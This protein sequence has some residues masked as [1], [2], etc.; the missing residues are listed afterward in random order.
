MDQAAQLKGA[1]D[2]RY[3]IER[4][5]GAGGMATVYL[6]RDVRHNRNVALKVLNPELGAVLGVERFLAEISVTANLQHPNLLPLFD[7]GDAGGLLFYVMPFVEGE[8][9][10]ARLEREKQLPVDEA[11][12]IAVAV[13]SAL[14]YAH[15][16]GVIHRDLKPEN[17][18]LQAGQPVIA[19]FGIALAV[20]K[21]GGNRITQT[22]LSLGTPQYMSPEQATGDRVIDGRSDIYSLAAV[23]YELLTGDPPYM[24]STSQAIIARVLTE[25]PRGVRATRASVP[26]HV[27]ATIARALEK[28]PADRFATAREFAEALQGRGTVATAAQ[29]AQAAVEAPP[30]AVAPP[31]R[32][33]ARVVASRWMVAA[34]VVAGAGAGAAAWSVTHRDEPAVVRFP[35]TLTSPER[36]AAGSFGN[37]IALSPD[38][39]LIAYA[40]IRPG[41]A[42]QIFIRPLADLDA[43]PP[44]GTENGEQ[45]FFSPN[46]QWIGFFTG[47]H[48]MKVSVAGGVATPIADVS[49]VCYGASWGPNHQIVISVSGRLEVV[50]DGGGTPRVLSRLNAT[51]SETQQRWPYVLADG[52]TVLYTSWKGTVLVGASIAVARLDRDSTQS[53]T[54]LDLRGSY[55]LGIVEGQLVY[56]SASAMSGQLMAVP[57]DVRGLRVTGTP[58]PVLDSVLMVA[59]GVAKAAVSRSGSLIHLSGS[60][61]QQLILVDPR[62]VTQSLSP[63]P[64]IFTFPRFSPDGNRI[65][66]TE[67]A[68]AATDI[69]I[70]DRMSGTRTRLTTGGN[71]DRPEWSTDGHRVLFSSD[72]GGPRALYWQPA[73]NTAPAELLFQAG[74]IDVYEGVFAPPDGSALVVRLGTLGA[75]D[76]WYRMRGADT[77]KKPIA[78][79]QYNEVAARVSPDGHWIAY[80][81]DESGPWQ[82]Y[83]RPFPGLGSRISISVEGGEF[84]VWSRDGSRLYYVANGQVLMAAPITTSPAFVTGPR[85][86]VYDGDVYFGISA[87]HPNYDVA[88]NGRGFLFLKPAGGEA[89]LIVTA[90]WK[91]D[92]R[93]RSAARPR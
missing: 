88:P 21:A 57:F 60:A 15:A 13:A 71:N 61:S 50:G 6:A 47:G 7:S 2:G 36:F 40:G 18:L 8:T 93:V 64:R 90:N 14:E 22:G 41:N 51:V 56:A 28:M 34:G 44:A 29:A 19:D 4:E 83:V 92:L 72:R 12:R 17:I 65:A 16:H 76:L 58:T 5:V 73:D 20:T 87:G 86:K 69:W 32:M 30:P 84:P 33:L 11:V 42:R 24:G 85:E 81:S 23:T 1:L 25:R 39:R 31:R 62:G 45:P 54:I 35:I 79:T 26:V 91:E 3:A 52:K 80:A 55:P 38:G 27:E 48:L 74:D 46:G 82:V 78:T 77:T 66:V 10:R 9:L 53:T 75:A 43:H 63:E 37:P 89:R 68:G 70:Y 67:A 59:N 49:P